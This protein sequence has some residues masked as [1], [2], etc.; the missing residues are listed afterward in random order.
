MGAVVDTFTYG[1]ALA[2][3][4]G[5]SMNRSPDMDQAGAWVLHTAIVA[6]PSSPAKKASGSDF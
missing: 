6:A 4:D 2:V 5:V 1:S 3:N